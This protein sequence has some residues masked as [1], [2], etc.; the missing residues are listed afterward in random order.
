MSI[1]SIEAKLDFLSRGIVVG[2]DSLQPVATYLAFYRRCAFLAGAGSS[3]PL[4]FAVFGTAASDFGLHLCDFDRELTVEW[5]ASGFDG[6]VAEADA[7]LRVLRVAAVGRRAERVVRVRSGQDQRVAS[8]HEARQVRRPGWWQ[9]TTETIYIIYV[10]IFRRR[11]V[12]QR[13]VY[14]CTSPTPPMSIEMV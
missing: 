3:L 13:K 8:P 2:R 5:V 9:L 14:T 6:D 11:C 7:D 10:F 12:D 1:S 4:R